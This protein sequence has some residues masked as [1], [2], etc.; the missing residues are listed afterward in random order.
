MKSIVIYF[1]LTENTKKVAFAIYKGMQSLMEQCDI[2]TIKEIDVSH[3]VDYD[4]IA[5]GSPVWGGPPSNVR[6]FMN[7]LP[8]FNKKHA[9]AFCTHGTAPE[10]FFPTVVSALTAKGLIVIGIN[11]WYG[12]SNLPVSPKPYLTDGHPDEIDLKEAEHFGRE[13]VEFSRRIYA[14]QTDLIPHLKMPPLNPSGGPSRPRPVLNTQKCTYPECR[15]CMD[16]CPM[17]AI[18]LSVSPPVFAKGMCRP[19]YFCEMICPEGAIEVDYVPLAED[20]IRQVK[21][22]FAEVLKKAESEGHFRRLVPIE[23]VGWRTPYYTVN[24]KHPRYV[25]PKE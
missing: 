6:L 14:G 16:N 18:D 15:L 1:S 13:M 4:L 10:R 5:L 12:S 17:D 7:N 2:S 25:I 20:E 22:I 21:T 23:K 9:V 19:C 24:N 11:D 3:L 8:L